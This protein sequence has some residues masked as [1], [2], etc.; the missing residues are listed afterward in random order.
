VPSAT[1][2]S[3]AIVFEKISIDGSIDHISRFPF[4]LHLQVFIK[5][6]EPSFRS[7]SLSL[8]LSRSLPAELSTAEI[9]RQQDIVW[10][11]QIYSHNPL[12]VKCIMVSFTSSAIM[13]MLAAPAVLG[14]EIAQQVQQG[15]VIYKV[16][17]R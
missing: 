4:D 16:R 11:K 15:P 7:L 14:A 12:E 1:T 9:S 17:T 10:A 13:A 3:I 5:S 6:N 8:S 2:N